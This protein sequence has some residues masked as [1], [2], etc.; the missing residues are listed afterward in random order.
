MLR[1]HPDKR[2]AAGEQIN[3]EGDY[4]ACIVKAYEILSNPAKRRAY[5]SVDPQF[6]D[7]TP[8]KSVKCPEEFFTVKVMLADPIHSFVEAFI[9]HGIL[10][11][12]YR[13]MVNG[14]R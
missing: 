7:Y 1:H 10:Y 14:F 13:F 8:S 12:V 9:T 4:F 6:D 11:F 2:Q 5:D 3:P